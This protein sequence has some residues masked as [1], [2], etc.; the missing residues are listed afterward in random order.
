MTFWILDTDHVSLWQRQHPIVTQRI[1]AVDLSLI[2]ITI[3]TAEE[4]LR[5]RL[6]VIR[7]ADSAIARVAAYGRFRETLDF[8][9]QFRRF[10][11]L[12]DFTMDAEVR[13]HDLK[14]Q[15]VRIGSQDLRI[16]AIALAVNGTVVT[17]NHRD[18]GQVSGLCLEDW[19]V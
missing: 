10:Q 13:Y 17:R 1:A 8:L 14:R 6:E 19:T 12:L 18:F 11:R 5:G 3:I 9:E 2:S 4:Q 16:A 15:R 7:R